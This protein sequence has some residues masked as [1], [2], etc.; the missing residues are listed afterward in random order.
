MMADD[1]VLVR[2]DLQARMLVGDTFH[3]TGQHFRLI[4]V[5]GVGIDGIG[6]GTGLI[7]RCLMGLVEEVLQFR[8]F[9]EHAFIEM[10]GD[11]QA[12]LR[13]DRCRGLDDRGGLR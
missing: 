8:F 9:P 2:R 7:S 3:R 4:D 12:V 11:G 10:F 1:V 6:Q 5:G 13:Q